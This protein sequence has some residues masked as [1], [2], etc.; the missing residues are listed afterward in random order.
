VSAVTAGEEEEAQAPVWRP[1]CCVIASL[2]E[3]YQVMIRITEE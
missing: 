1:W 2:F 3:L